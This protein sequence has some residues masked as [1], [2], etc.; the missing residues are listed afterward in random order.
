MMERYAQT[1]THSWAQVCEPGEAPLLNKE[2]K[3]H[4]KRFSCTTPSWTSGRAVQGHKESATTQEGSFERGKLPARL[5]TCAYMQAQP[6]ERNALGHE[7]RRIP[8]T[9]RNV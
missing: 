7:K 9:A 5:C 4:A 8:V 3:R 2:A 1:S 6:I